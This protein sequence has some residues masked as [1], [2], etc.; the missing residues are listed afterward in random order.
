MKGLYCLIGFT[1]L[2]A[3][4]YM[5]IM[6]KETVRFSNFYNLLDT[7][8]K[9]VYEKI[10]KERLMIYFVGMSLGLG[11]GILFYIKN[12][13]AEYR[14]CKFLMIIYAVKLGFYYFYPKS[15]LML[16]SLTNTQQTDAW[17]DIYTEMKER[18]KYSLLIGLIGY[19][20]VSMMWC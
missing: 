6:N 14:L 13:K 9:I 20:F 16:Y 15:P 8:Q 4:L 18:W 5:S 1:L 3:S 10:V 17:A 7:K 2:F 11:L 12:P 19:L